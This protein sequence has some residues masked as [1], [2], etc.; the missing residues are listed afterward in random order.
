M[1]EIIDNFLMGRLNEAD[2]KAVEAK[3]NANPAF[4]K[5]VQVQ[6]DLLEAS[7]ITAAKTAIKKT[8][9]A[10]KT[11]KA[12]KVIVLSTVTAAIL[13]LG[14]YYLYNKAETEEKAKQESPI[15]T[16]S[17][18]NSKDT[19]IE[20]SG[21][22]I[23]HIPA[24]AFDEEN[25]NIEVKEALN[26]LDIMEQGLSTVSNGEL[27][28]TAGMF[29]ITGSANGKELKLKKEI[30]AQIP[31]EEIDSEMMLFDSEEVDGEVNWVNPINI[32]KNLINVPFETLDFYPPKYVKTLNKLGV[33][34]D[35]KRIADSIY[36]SFDCGVKTKVSSVESVKFEVIEEDLLSEDGIKYTY[37]NKNENTLISKVG[38][39]YGLKYTNYFVGNIVDLYVNVSPPRGW[40]IVSSRSNDCK[41]TPLKA[42]LKFKKNNSF[43]LVGGLKPIG[44]QKYY[45]E[46]FE[47]DLFAFEDDA[48]FIQK[49]KI[50]I[51]NPVIIADFEG[52]MIN[53]TTST[54][55]NPPTFTFINN[56]PQTDT[57]P[58]ESYK[59]KAIC[60]ASIQALRTPKF[61]NTFIATKEFETRLKH[62]FEICNES[63]LNVYINNLDKDLWV[64]DSIV[65]GMLGGSKGRIFKRFAK[66]RLGNTKSVSPAFAQLGVYHNKKREAYAV[67]LKKTKR[68]QRKA[69]EKE[70][71]DMA[72]KSMERSNKSNQ[73]AAANF[74]KELEINMNE[75][76]RQ[77]G[78][79]PKIKTN[80]KY[81]TV[82]VGNSNWKNLDKFV[83]ESTSQR[84]SLKTKYNGKDISIKYE[85]LM[86][87][88]NGYKD[89]DFVRS[90]LIPDSL[91]SYKKMKGEK[92]VF[93]ET[94]NE[95]LHYQVVCLGKKGEDYFY[96]TQS[97]GN[98]ENS[99]NVSLVKTEK[100][101]LT[102]VLKQ[103]GKT[104]ASWNLDK[105]LDY[106]I[107]RFNY[108]EKVE[109][110]AEDAAFRRKV[111]EVIWPCN[112]T[113][114]VAPPPRIY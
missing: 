97:I 68:A 37:F 106:E 102:R 58:I 71:N 92:G 56:P 60:P 84:K 101:A 110:R 91:P 20:T 29:K 83:I 3:I 33:D 100:A 51:E 99:L 104:T 44:D 90:Y 59:N 98:G 7:K 113:Q 22:I 109:K 96:F 25:V 31:T 35:N 1:E 19:V 72:N 49:V 41:V 107:E 88:I 4:A 85:K 65:A 70:S 74:R 26:A 79:D 61:A 77:A 5:E 17:I 53:S 23:L 112:M 78:L 13:T 18:D 103:T 16:F 14:A 73:D 9:K 87:K 32:K 63:A 89:F 24:N 81:Y 2:R 38:W 52:Q 64:S 62:L 43:E 67:A 86:V 36:Y 108:K 54:T 46:S 111:E 114:S 42:S 47:C 57:T 105:E 11:A 12:A 93:K 45:D 82:P 21:G 48:K 55:L 28:A 76:Y 30:T 69:W 80:K 94:L 95:L 40:G 39:N 10:I 15:S 27:L 50:L 75:A 66:E 6:K 8:H 34:G